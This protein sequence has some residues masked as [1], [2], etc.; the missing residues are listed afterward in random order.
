MR[1]R[2]SGIFSASLYVGIM[3][4]TN[5]NK[6]LV[7]IIVSSLLDDRNDIRSFVTLEFKH[8]GLSIL[9]LRNIQK[10][11]IGHLTAYVLK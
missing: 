8:Y 2:S 10:F 1:S 7:P 3:I 4:E 9:R 11:K 5:G 6:P